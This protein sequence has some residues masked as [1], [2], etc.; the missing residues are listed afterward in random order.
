MKEAT[1]QTA[2]KRALERAGA[3]VENN[4]GSAHG[5]GRPDLSGCLQGL[6]FGFELKR[7]GRARKGTELQ[8]HVLAQIR[9]AGGWAGVVNNLDQI[10]DILRR[11]PFVCRHCLGPLERSGETGLWCPACKRE[12]HG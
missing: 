6:Y 8:E 12:H 4:H 7:P 1:L 2:A 3:Y 11:W 9:L 10:S 5:S